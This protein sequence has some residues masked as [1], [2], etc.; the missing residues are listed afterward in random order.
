MSDNFLFALVLLVV[1]DVISGLYKAY[2]TNTLSSKVMKK[3]ILN[4]LS[5]FLIVGLAWILDNFVNSGILYQT[6]CIF[7]ISEEGLSV[8]ENLKDYI[9]IPDKLRDALGGLDG[10]QQI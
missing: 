1:G 3:G 7:Y 6:I 2:E 4:K 10:K 5:L 9:P 8:L